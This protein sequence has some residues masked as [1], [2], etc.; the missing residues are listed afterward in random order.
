VFKL[1]AFE[2]EKD[3]VFTLDEMAL[4]STP[5][6]HRLN[7]DS[8]LIA[9]IRVI[10]SLT[11]IIFWINQSATD[12]ANRF[13]SFM[14]TL[15]D[16]ELLDL[17]KH[18]SEAYSPIKNAQDTFPL[19]TD[20]ERKDFL[21]QVRLGKKEAVYAYLERCEALIFSKASTNKNTALHYAMLSGDYQLVDNF[22]FNFGLESVENIKGQTPIQ[23][24]RDS[25][26]LSEYRHL[27]ELLAYGLCIDRAIKD[28]QLPPIVICS[29]NATGRDSR[30][31]K[32]DEKALFET[33]YPYYFERSFEKGIDDLHS[34]CDRSKQEVGFLF[35]DN[36]W[37]NM[38]MESASRCTEDSVEFFSVL[39][40]LDLTNV[41]TDMVHVHIH[42]KA[43]EKKMIERACRTFPKK[44]GEVVGKVISA[45]PSCEDIQVYLH[46]LKRFSG[47]RRPI[48]KFMIVTPHGVTEIVLNANKIN[49]SNYENK[50][51]GNS[52][53]IV[54]FI[55]T[56]MNR[57]MI[58]SIS[59]CID[60]VNQ[61][62]GL[63][64]TFTSRK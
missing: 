38:T 13:I 20:G 27:S 29:T 34:L 10:L 3:V 24:L 55:G 47:L 54:T 12:G 14:D 28:P 49:I 4:Y 16:D 30:F 39:R 21:T 32:S 46:E 59:D 42:P 36:K 37:F 18:P 23:L 6:E 2:K 57:K 41:K 7:I 35:S 44:L 8:N 64:L 5:V 15:V 53:D 52:D 33:V 40:D 58:T 63:T 56:R 26:K 50:L 48:P 9:I 43:A 45:L 11:Q 22:S 19:Y 60:F 31:V 25:V 1:V 51:F 17:D 61:V 62:E